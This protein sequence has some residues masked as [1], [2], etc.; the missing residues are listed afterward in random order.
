M[1][2]FHQAPDQELQWVFC[3]DVYDE[4][5]DMLPRVEFND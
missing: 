2:A 1:L 3:H 5:N 4:A